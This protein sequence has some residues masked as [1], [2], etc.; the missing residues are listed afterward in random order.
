MVAQ[1]GYIWSVATGD[2][3][4]RWR[5]VTIQSSIARWSDYCCATDEDNLSASSAAGRL[6]G[7]H[8]T[9]LLGVPRHQ[10]KTSRKSHSVVRHG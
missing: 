2:N 3:E 10:R 5:L 7:P 4:R 9:T 6:A 1:R 8:H